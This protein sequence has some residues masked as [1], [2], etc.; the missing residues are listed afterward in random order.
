MPARL[1]G[2]TKTYGTAVLL[3]L[4]TAERVTVSRH[5]KS[6][7]IRLRGRTEALE[8]HVRQ[9]AWLGPLVGA[10]VRRFGG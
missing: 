4:D 10:I 8:T 7:V 5:S 9:Y 2:E 1:E 6:T 3:G